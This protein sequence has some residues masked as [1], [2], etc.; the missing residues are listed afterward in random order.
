MTSSSRSSINSSNCYLSPSIKQKQAVRVTDGEG[1]ELTLFSS[2]PSIKIG[3]GSKVT[4]GLRLHIKH[5]TPKTTCTNV[6]PSA[7]IISTTASSKKMKTNQKHPTPSKDVGEII[8][9][10][11]GTPIHPKSQ[12]HT[13][14]YFLLGNLSIIDVSLMS[15]P[16]PRVLFG[17][18]S[19]NNSI[20][21]HGCFVQLFF[22]I[23]V[24]NMDS[25]LLAI[26]SLDR[27]AAICQPL[28]Y[29]T[30]MSKRMCISLVNSSWVIVCL[31]S[32]LYTVMFSSLVYCDSVVHHFFCDGPALLM[33]SCTDTSVIEMFIFF[34]GSIIVMSPMFFILASY[35]L[36][37]RAVLRLRTTSGRKKTFSTCSSHLTLV[38]IFY[39]SV[40]FMYFR[41]NSLFSPVYD[42]V[43]SVLYTVL[44]PMLNPF[45]YSLRNKETK[46][47]ATVRDKIVDMQINLD[48]YTAHPFDKE[49]D[50]ILK[51]TVEK[52]KSEILEV[53]HNKY[54][55]DYKKGQKKMKT[56]Q[57]HPTPSKDVGEIIE[58][59]QGTPIHRTHP[60]SV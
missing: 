14:M 6:H 9:E 47:L 10:R 37:I 49:I 21:F 36:I 42:R 17:L 59:R 12:L 16:I 31:H 48:T 3:S 58:E 15:I 4:R 46:E 2:K 34:E 39:S 18:L 11:Q 38:I 43:V 50:V 57:K 44:T 30:I 27:Y 25:F 20:T 13:P 51:T 45:I 40:I 22:F 56:N 54:L 32:L 7:L 41:P 23:A 33:N 55:N 60:S 53:K 35:T 1:A 28:R 29:S 19:K 52:I 8:E 5:S 26:M 24:A